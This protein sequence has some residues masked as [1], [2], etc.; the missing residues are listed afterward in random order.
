M[1]HFAIIGSDGIA[2]E[3]GA[4]LLSEG[5][6]SRVVFM[7]EDEKLAEKATNAVNK[8]AC[9][10]ILLKGPTDLK[11][12][13]TNHDIQQVIINIGGYA[14]GKYPPITNKD[15]DYETISQRN[16]S[17]MK[18]YYEKPAEYL[19]AAAAYLKERYA[20]NRTDIRTSATAHLGKDRNIISIVGSRLTKYMLGI[21]T[22]GSFIAAKSALNSLAMSLSRDM[23]AK[24]ITVSIVNPDSK[25][26]ISSI[27]DSFLLMYRASPS[28]DVTA[29]DLVSIKDCKLGIYNPNKNLKG[30]VAVVTGGSNGIGRGIA[31]GLASQGCDIAIIGRNEKDLRSAAQECKAASPTSVIKYYQV[32]VNDSEL[33]KKTIEDA[34]QYFGRISCLVCSAG[35]NRRRNALLRDSQ[36]PK[37]WKI[38]SP[39]VWG[40][41]VDV[42]LKSA[43]S[44][45][46]Y[47]LPFLADSACDP[48]LRGGPT[49]IYISSSITKIP[50]SPV[51]GQVSYQT[52]KTA[53][54]SFCNGIHRDVSSFGIKSVAFHPELV[55]TALGTRSQNGNKPASPEYLIQ[56]TDMSLAADYAIRCLSNPISIDF[57]NVGD[58]Q[59]KNKPPPVKGKL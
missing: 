51:G 56:I 6:A 31:I 23:T 21:P 53:L 28:C 43:M 12:D 47:C 7:D 45:T 2:T 32:D 36:N 15:E 33:L 4:S 24:G 57:L 17:V 58:V 44:V 39:E 49:I 22:K 34:A 46:Q 11:L 50:W 8:N 9:R 40:D 5:I 38:A 20:S 29:I 54:T 55:D 35:V 30:H 1:G 48:R 26:S 52:T 42:N 37:K 27:I 25:C 41:M 10:G 14:S 16:A 59:P 13:L 19:I 18:A 3:L